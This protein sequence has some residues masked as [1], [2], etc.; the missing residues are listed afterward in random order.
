L[1]A[2]LSFA[3][4][5]PDADRRLL[6]ETERLQRTLDGRSEELRR[7]TEQWAHRLAQAGARTW[8]R[9]H[10]L[11]LEAERKRTGTVFLGFAGDSLVCWSGQPAMR[12]GLFAP[13]DEAHVRLTDATWLHARVPAG[14]AV[15]HGLRPVW[16][17]PAIENRHLRS[18]FHPSLAA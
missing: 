4:G 17:T 14:D 12:P 18:S 13:D 2:G 7:A 1:F 8:M 15:L 5:E 10:A 9:A 6:R 3:V 11:E 16:R